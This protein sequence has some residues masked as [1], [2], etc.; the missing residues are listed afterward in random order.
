MKISLNKDSGYNRIDQLTS[1][2][3][4]INEVAYRTSVIV[5][6]KSAVQTWKSPLIHELSSTDFEIAITTQ[7]EILLL[8]TGARHQMPSTEL[9]AYFLKMRIGFE[10]MTTKA[11]CR[12]YNLLADDQRNVMAYLIMDSCPDHS[13]QAGAIFEGN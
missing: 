10:V 8:G 2:E 5:S 12:T 1:S 11:A 4:L 3:F 7:P 13:T 6:P 9:Q